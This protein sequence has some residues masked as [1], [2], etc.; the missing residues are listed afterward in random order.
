MV[1]LNQRILYKLVSKGKKGTLG[2]RTKS[3]VYVVKKHECMKYPKCTADKVI[4][5]FKKKPK[6]I[7]SM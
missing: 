7:K 2:P 3:R 6:N 4:V 1:E 5:I